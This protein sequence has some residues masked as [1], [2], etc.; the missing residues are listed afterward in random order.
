M[1]NISQAFW[2]AIAFVKSFA[3]DEYFKESMQKWTG[4]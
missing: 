1:R 3:T 4:P 2:K